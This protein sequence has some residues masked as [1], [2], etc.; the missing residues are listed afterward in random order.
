MVLVFLA[1]PLVSIFYINVTGFNVVH[2]QTYPSDQL[3]PS[4]E[5]THQFYFSLHSCLIGSPLV[6]A[7][8]SVCS[9][10]SHSCIIKFLTLASSP[11]SPLSNI[12]IHKALPTF[13]SIKH[14]WLHSHLI[15]FFFK[16]MDILQSLC[17]PQATY[18]NHLL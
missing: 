2:V 9:Q 18:F 3:L 16:F 14:C 15:E 1:I 5:A 6:L 10:P 13:R 8:V 12:Q 4:V 11:F 7:L 17:T